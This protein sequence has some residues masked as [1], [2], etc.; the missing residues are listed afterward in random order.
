MYYGKRPL[1][2]SIYVIS[3]STPGGLSSELSIRFGMLGLSHVITTGCTSS[4]DALGYATS[5]IRRGR[6]DVVL[7]GGADAPIAEGIMQGFLLMRIVP[8]KWNDAPEKASRPFNKDREGFV[9]S[10]GS[11]MFVLEEKERAR[12]RAAVIYGEIAGY[13]SS[14]EAFHPV[15]LQ[16]DG[17]ANMRAIS[18]AAEEARVS[19]D[20]IDHVNLHG[21]ATPLN[22]EI[23][24]QAMKQFFGKR[25]YEIPMNSTKSMIG[26]PQGASGAAGLAAT[27]LLMQEDMIHPTINLDSPDPKCDLDYVPYKARQKR[28]DYALCNTLGFGSKCSALLVKRSSG[29]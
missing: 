4:T 21:T 3:A 28:I 5:E 25:A 16:Y 17:T 18:L 8:T 7:A 13:G 1:D 2:P 11:W 12:R 29:E 26:H 22:D 19:P 15:S 23:E 9:L 27:L 14:C 6:L 24:T 10:E 20:K